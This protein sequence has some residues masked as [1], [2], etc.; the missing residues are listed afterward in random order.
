MNSKYSLLIA[1]ILVALAQI[2]V[3]IRM[4][5]DKEDVLAN[6]TEYKFKT[7]PVDPVD[8][9]RGKYITLNYEGNTVEIQNEKDWM[10]GERIYVSL[11]SDNEGFAQIT[12]V[13]KEKPKDNQDYIIAKVDFVT[14]DGSNKLTIF[15]PF[16]RYYMEE[17]KALKA[18]Q[19]YIYAQI[20]TNQITYALVRIKDGDAVLKDVLIDGISIREIVKTNQEVGK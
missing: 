9:F 16:N 12:S 15:Y 20:D 2:Y 11:T 5:L 1:F 18:E 4:I 3:P 8:P 10:F 14:D 7:A 6:G 19:T 17:S 13:S